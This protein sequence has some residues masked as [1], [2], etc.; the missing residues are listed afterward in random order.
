MFDSTLAI[1]EPRH[2]KN[3]SQHTHITQ[4]DQNYDNFHGTNCCNSSEF[5]LLT[6]PINV[7]TWGGEKLKT[8]NASLC[9]KTFKL[10]QYGRHQ[11]TDH[12]LRMSLYWWCYTTITQAPEIL[13]PAIK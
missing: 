13:T 11:Y 8:A 4:C 6:K 9:S 1:S 10:F 3:A 5:C 12:L 7:E 2:Q